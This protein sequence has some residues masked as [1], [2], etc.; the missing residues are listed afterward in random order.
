MKKN[1][2]AL[3]FLLAAVAVHAQDRRINLYSAYVFDDKFETY[4]SSTDYYTGKIMGGYQWGAGVEIKPSDNMGVELL[5]YHQNTQ[6][7]V[8]YYN[9]AA[10]T[11]TLDVGVSYILL[12]VNRYFKTGKV[13]PYGGILLGTSIFNNQHPQGSE[14]TSKVK[15]ALGARLGVNIWTS[16]RVALKLQA[17]LLSSVQGFGGGFYFGT[18]GSGTSLSTYSSI[19][20][21]GL[22]GGLSFKLAK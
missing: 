22:G 5:Y 7:P 1:I 20:Q 4:N 6:A 13:E 11:R 3:C 18:G 12:G 14:E 19:T 2:L 21:L 8:S 10:T 9:I 17:Q 15:F 16:D